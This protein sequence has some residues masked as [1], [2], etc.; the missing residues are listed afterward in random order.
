MSD[1]ETHRRHNALV[2]IPTYNE[3]ESLAL[4]VEELLDTAAVDILVIDD[5]SPDGTGQV[6][7]LWKKKSGGRVDVLHRGRKLGLGTA[8][9]AAFGLGLE[10]GYRLLLQMDGD[11]SHQP[12]YVP[13]LLRASES[14]DVVIGSRYVEG[15]DVVNW[16]KLREGLSRSGGIYARTILQLPVRDVTSGFRC[17]RREVLDAIDL[18]TIQTTGY[19]FQIE[20][21]HR[22]HKLGFRLREVPIVFYERIGG[23]SKMTKSIVAEAITSVWSMRFR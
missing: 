2:C 8:Y 17:Y 9:V 6:A 21:T 15:G 12:R 16:S 22:A 7:E 23:R 19:A 3:R 14:A 11:S 1:D 10:R 20:M 5:A 13:E 18:H 4:L